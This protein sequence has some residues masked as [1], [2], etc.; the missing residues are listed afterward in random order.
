HQYTIRSPRRDFIRQQLKE[1]G[2]PSV[3]YY[4]IPLH[5]QEAMAFMGHR[6][7][8]FPVAEQVSK[9]VLSLPIYPELDE[10]DIRFTSETIRK[11]LKG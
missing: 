8:D 9:E 5:L 7:G 2:I 3:V 6:E 1:H 11:C 10:A 4:P